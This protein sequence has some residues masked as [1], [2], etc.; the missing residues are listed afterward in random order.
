MQ[1]KAVRMTAKSWKSATTKAGLFMQ[2]RT[3]DQ[4]DM[5]KE[6]DR[7]REYTAVSFVGYPQDC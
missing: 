7:S 2:G 3:R 5:G 1:V 6:C 4:L